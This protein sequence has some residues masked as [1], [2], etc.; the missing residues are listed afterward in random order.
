MNTTWDLL[1]TPSKRSVVVALDHGINMGAVEQ[2][3]D[4]KST[5]ESVLAG[6]PDGVLV[7]PHFAEHY[8]DILARSKTDVLLTADFVSPSS[9][10][11]EDIGT[12]VQQRAFSTDHLCE[13]DP[14]GVK[15]VLAFGRQNRRAFERNVEYITDLAEE[16]RGTDI[17]HIVETVMWGNEIPSRFETDPQYVA[18]AARI[19]WEL[20]ADILKVPYTGD[21]ESFKPIVDT[22]PV[23]LMILGGPS[24]GSVRALLGDVSDA[25]DAGARG[26][27]VGRSIWQTEDPAAVVSALREI[28]HE[29]AT[30]DA[31]WRA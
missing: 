6:R 22:A 8:G 12:W 26:L 7:G 23:P 10:P 28:V 1:D 31:V 24:S 15:S 3:E 14:V 13:I 25:M 16:L 9:Q 17:P 27:I 4:P 19:G 21:V 20:G 30:V 11:G 18:N 2:F 29:E 5:L